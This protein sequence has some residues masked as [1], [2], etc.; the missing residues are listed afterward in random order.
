MGKRRRP[1]PA[2]TPFERA[3]LPDIPTAKVQ[4]PDQVWMNS[5]YQV[6][7]YRLEGDMGVIEHLSIKRRDRRIIR[8]WRHLQRI[9]NE[10]CG[11]EREGV[12]LFPAES[13]LVDTANQYHLYVLPEGVSLGLGFSERLVSEDPGECGAVQRRFDEDCRPDDLVTAEEMNRK[14]Q[15]SIE[16]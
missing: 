12:E 14:V 7:V 11:P 8:D 5:L 13:R 6:S 1:D 3:V 9:K 15:E 2:W 10:L 4:P 16:K